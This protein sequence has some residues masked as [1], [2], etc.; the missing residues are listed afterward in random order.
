[1]SESSTATELALAGIGQ[2]EYEYIRQVVYDHS[3]INLGAE[4]KALVSARV[5][6]RLRALKLPDFDIYCQYLRSAQGKREAPLLVEAVS[7]NHTYFFRES[8]HFDFLREVAAPAWQTRGIGALR[9]WSAA[10]SSGEEPYTIAITLAETLGFDV[11]WRVLATDI[12]ARMLDLGR[13]AIYSGERLSHVPA[14]LQKKYF[15]RGVGASEGLFRVKE[16]IRRRVEFAQIN[17]LQTTYPF[18]TEFDAVF[19]RNVMIYFDCETQ[20]TLVEK[21]SPFVA[22]GGYLMIGHSECLRNIR[23]PFQLMEPSVYRKN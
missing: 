8:R 3:R 4:K 16:E 17:L 21:I 9:I 10:A 6:K 7:T 18:M 12:S 13:S 14:G 5:A 1:V 23:S 2:E 22:G 20:E 15:Q 11:D 19:C